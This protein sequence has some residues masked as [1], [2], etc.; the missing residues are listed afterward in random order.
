MNIGEAKKRVEQLRAEVA[1]HDEKYHTLDQPEISDTAYDALK[2]ELID[3][4]EQFPKLRSADSPTQTVGGQI[5]GGFQKTKHRVSQWSY[6]NIFDFEGLQKWQEKIARM[7]AKDE[8]L[9]EEKLD[10]ICEL[11]IDGLKL[12]LTYDDGKLITGA[13]RGDGSVGEDITPSVK[14]IK[15]IPHNVSEKNAFV[16]VG[17][18]WMAKT[19]LENINAQRR[20]GGLT[21]YAN[22][23][24][25]AA[26]TLRQLDT[27]VV[28]GRN[29]QIFSYDI[30]FIDSQVEQKTP[31]HS[32]ELDQLEKFGFDVND[33]WKL[34][35][36]IEQIQEFYESWIN[37]RHDMTYDVDG[38][39][40]KINN[41]KIARSL[42]YTAKSPRFGVAYKFPAEQVTTVVE[43]IHIQVGRTGVLT[44]VA[45]LRPVR[46]AGS[47]VSRATLHNEDEINRLGLKIGDTVIIEKAGDI[48]PKVIQVVENLRSGSEQDFSMEKYLKK[49][50]ITAHKENVAGRESAAWYVDDTN[51]FEVQKE[52]ITHF[53]SKKG[54]NIDGLGEKVVLALM[55][56]G[57][58]NEY[59]DLYELKI[60]DVLE[61]EGFK[62]KS[63]QNLIGAI[64]ASKIPALAK[65][66]F[67]LGI[68]HVGEETA[69]LLANY[70]SSPVILNLFQD[71]ISALKNVPLNDL[72][73]ID[74]IGDVV[75]QSIYDY[76]HNADSVEKLER[77]LKFVS[78]QITQKKESQNS[79]ITGK[80]FVLTGTMESMSRDDAKAKIKE[81]GG[82]VANS[83]SK[84]TDY[85]VAGSDPGSKYDNAIKLGVEVLTEQQFKE[86]FYS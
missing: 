66:L 19:E 73:F 28:A 51:L 37:K 48:I 79:N 56:N 20:S 16:A 67:A 39:V 84:N 30:D 26:G 23:R 82:K 75:A 24:N 29:L 31:T 6:D 55:N 34:C 7:I 68:R 8:S 78:P 2:Q 71:P 32:D 33:E 13:T 5:L 45:H 21:E 54:M 46:V 85:V 70:V 22:P 74:G 42:G 50:G 15:S 43:D 40:I 41:K 27:S 61:L 17:E 3:I 35:S 11:K 14:Q 77:L 10:Y 25:L 9:A 4:E 52:K 62:E 38:I 64:D 59:A 81:W 58:V 57:L 72:E 65:F 60:G 69:E 18:A 63:A 86:I 1:R 83:V 49:Q 80:T 44:P 12:V 47:T 76:F 53:V 36:N